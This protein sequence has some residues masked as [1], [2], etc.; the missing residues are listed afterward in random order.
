MKANRRKV[1]KVKDFPPSTDL[2][3]IK[4]RLPAKTLKA[5]KAFGGGEREMYPVGDVMG[6]GFMLSPQFPGTEKRQLFPL[7]PEMSPAEM[8][9]WTVVGE[10]K[11]S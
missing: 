11:M 6:Y 4:V 2:T 10:G 7:P 5:F 9:D 3:T 8:L 1:L